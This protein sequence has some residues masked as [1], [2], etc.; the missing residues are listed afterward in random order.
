MAFSVP[1]FRLSCDL[2]VLAYKRRP[3]AYYCVCVCVRRNVFQCA[4]VMRL[5]DD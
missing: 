4:C 2:L 1:N 5:C 3:Y